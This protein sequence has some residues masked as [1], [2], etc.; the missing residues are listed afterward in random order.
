MNSLQTAV[1]YAKLMARLG[2][3]KYFAQG[4]D[5]GSMIST[6]LALVAPKHVLGTNCA[7]LMTVLV[8]INLC[9]DISQSKTFKFARMK[10]NL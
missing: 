10:G 9:K 1:I 7:V 8:E 2:Y 3:D 6:N 5:W 4:G